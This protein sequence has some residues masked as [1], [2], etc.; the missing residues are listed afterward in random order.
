LGVMNLANTLPAI[1]TAAL[2]MRASGHLALDAAMPLILI[3]CSAACGV[4]ALLCGAM[5]DGVDRRKS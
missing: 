1:L 5:V 3:T 4:A 2:T